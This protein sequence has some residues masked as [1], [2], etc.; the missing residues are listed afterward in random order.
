MIYRIIEIKLF[1]WDQAIWT[2]RKFSFENP[3]SFRG[4]WKWANATPTESILKWLRLKLK[5]TEEKKAVL[6]LRCDDAENQNAPE[7][8]EFS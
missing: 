3:Q 6:T 5:K 1:Q 2:N 7:K 4:S 8:E